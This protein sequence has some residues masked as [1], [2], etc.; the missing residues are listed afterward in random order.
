MSD[1]DWIEYGLDA[2]KTLLGEPYQ[3]DRQI[4]NATKNVEKLRA[5]WNEEQ[6]VFF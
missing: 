6:H 1:G 3:K 4:K 5:T 2:G